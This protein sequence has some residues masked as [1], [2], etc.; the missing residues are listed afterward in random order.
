MKEVNLTDLNDVFYLENQG[1]YEISSDRVTEEKAGYD[2]EVASFNEQF[3]DYYNDIYVYNRNLKIDGANQNIAY[4]NRENEIHFNVN[5]P[6]E[7]KAKVLEIRDKKEVLSTLIFKDV[8]EVGEYQFHPQ[9]EEFILNELSISEEKLKAPE[10]ITDKIDKKEGYEAELVLDMKNKEL[11]Q[12]LRYNGYMLSSNVAVSYDSYKAILKNLSYLLDDNHRN[13][14]LTGYVNEQIEKDK[15]K[16]ERKEPVYQEGMNVRYQ[17]KEYIISEIQDYKTY[18]TIKLDDS[19]GYLNG[20]ITGSEIIPFRNE[21]ELDLEIISTTEKLQEQSINGEDLILLDIEEYNKKGL[22]VIFQNKEYEITGNNFN[23][24]GMSRLQL[25][26]NTEKLMTEISYTPQRPVANLYAKKDLLERFNL[27]EKNSEKS[28]EAKQMSLTDIFEEQDTTKGKEEISSEKERVP[29][30]IGAKV[31]YQGEEYTVS[32]FEYNNILE[33]NDIWLNPVSKNNHQIPIVSFSDREELNEKLIVIDTNLNLGEDKS[34]LLHHSLDVINDKGSVIANQFIVKVDNQNREL[35]VYSEQNPN[36]HREFELSFD[37]LNGLGQIDGDGNNLKLT[38]HKKETIDKKLKSYHSWKEDGEKRGIPGI[39][40][41]SIT[42]P[43]TDEMF[44]QMKEYEEK[45]KEEERYAPDDKY[46]GGIP[47]INYKITKEDEILP[48]SERL[49]NNIEAIKVLKEI[50]ER[51]SHATKEEQDILSRYVGWGGLSDVFDEEKGGQWK[52]AREFLKENLSPSEYDA[53][54]ESTLTAFYTPKIVI[55]SI[56]QAVLNMGFES[57]N[58]LEPSM[59]TGRFIGNLPDSMKGSKFYGVELDSISGRIA[60]RLY[61]NAKIQIKGFEETTFSN[62]LFDVAVG[63][64]P[65]GEYK[66]VDREYEKNNFLIHDFFFAKTLDKVRSGGVVAFISS[67]GTM[68]KKSE[69]IRRYISERAE[70]LGAIRLPN[71]T[72]KGEAGTEVT[73]DIIFLKKRD[74]LVKLDEEWVKLGTDERGL[75]YNKYFVD[76]PD[77]VLGNMEEISSRFGT[78]LACVADENSTLKEQLDTAIKNIK[79]SYEKIEL[80]NEFEVETIPADDSVKNYSYAVIDDKVYFREN[81]V[82]QKLNLNKNDEEKVR[83]YLGIEKAL[84]QVIAYQKEDY[85]DTEIKEKQGELNRIYDEFSKKYG[86]LNSKANKKLFREDANYSLLST[87]E[88]L[89]KEGNFIEKSD[90]FTKRT[91]KKAVAIEHTDNLTEALILS[92]SQKGKVNFEYME[93]L[94]E[95]TRGEIIE[96]LKG[97]IFLNLDGFDPSDTTPFSS[98]IDLGDFSRSYVTAD[99]YL[100]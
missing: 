68:D 81:S 40:G 65:F 69:D 23:P 46:L 58:I 90:I 16:E 86:I 93:K 51:H 55:D 73:S 74:R 7:E 60:S 15:A 27:N 85:S 13:I 8:K 9:S 4:I 72:F 11:R 83:A 53:A 76:N 43:I 12:H 41:S 45:L 98:A 33:K 91:I 62:N 96:G 78:S 56:Y 70:F 99:E 31:I 14:M 30:N 64:V 88:K 49:K 71:N 59:G 18:K 82:M 94:T 80:N 75:T 3:P 52:D 5:L 26:S 66:I 57:G 29:V 24:V 67:S 37:Y 92:I 44:W 28:I 17:G 63:N 77:M 87:L 54:R 21:R 48:P 19:E 1:L 10:H 22:S 2:F 95:K 38:K 84:R 89:D 39:A 47:P 25:V 34:E 36:S 20:F 100:S 6:E 50:E 61:P 35:T 42:S 79:G 32:A 97:E